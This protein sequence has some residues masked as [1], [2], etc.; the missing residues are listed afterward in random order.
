MEEVDIANIN[1]VG[2][3]W[4]SVPVPTS[5]DP[6][7]SPNTSTKQATLTNSQSAKLEDIARLYKQGME[8]LATSDQRTAWDA[9]FAEADA[10]C[11]GWL[12][13]APQLMAL[14]RVIKT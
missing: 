9:L 14:K 13:H 3:H 8:R 2:H 1:A 11:D 10:F 7:V 4:P 5:S 6:N 12:T